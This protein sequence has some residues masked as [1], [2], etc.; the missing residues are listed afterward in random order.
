LDL[1]V[2]YVKVPVQQL[3]ALIN[4]TNCATEFEFV[5]PEVQQLIYSETDWFII[6]GAGLT[7]THTRNVSNRVNP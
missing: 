1:G 3:L 5:I 2:G 7:L 4:L 6:R